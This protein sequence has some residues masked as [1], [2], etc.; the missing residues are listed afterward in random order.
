MAVRVVGGVL[1]W[2][3]LASLAAMAS[4]LGHFGRHGGESGGWRFDV[5]AV[6]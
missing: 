4:E 2:L 3:R 5:A 6:G 1:M